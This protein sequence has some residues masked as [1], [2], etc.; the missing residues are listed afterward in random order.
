MRVAR[1]GFICF[2]CLLSRLQGAIVTSA[3]ADALAVA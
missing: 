3:V 1:N 2:A